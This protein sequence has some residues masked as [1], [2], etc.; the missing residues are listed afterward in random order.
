LTLQITLMFVLFSNFFQK[1]LIDSV[2][3]SGTTKRKVFCALFLKLPIK[4]LNIINVLEFL[5]LLNN[6][7]NLSLTIHFD[8]ERNIQVQD[9]PVV[10][11]YDRGMAQ[12]AWSE[13]LK[14][15]NDDVLWI[16]DFS[17]DIPLVDGWVV[18]NWHIHDRLE[19]CFRCA[20]CF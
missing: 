4:L 18:K 14:E 3:F 9:L 8:R 12:S 20:L 19:Q 13:A 16:N 17:H 11:V 10:I 15:L 5:F 1:N 6:L 2:F 7:L